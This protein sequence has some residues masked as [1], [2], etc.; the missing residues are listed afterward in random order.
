MAASSRLNQEAPLVPTDSRLPEVDAVT[1]EEEQLLNS[2]I[3]RVNQT[4]LQEKDVDAEALL[5][6]GLGGNPNVLYILAQC[7]LVQNIALDQ[8]KAQVA[9]LQQQVQQAQQQPAHAT[10]F[11]GN[12]LGHHDP[13]PLP[14]TFA[15]PQQSYVPPPGY[16][17]PQY[18]QPLYIPGSQPSFM[19]GAMQTAAGV[20]AGALAFEGVEAVLHGLGGFGHTGYGWGGPGMGMGGF[21]MGSGMMGGGFERPEETIVNNYYDQPGGQEQHFHESADRTGADQGGARLSDASYEQSGDNQGS[22][23]NAGLDDNGG[24]DNIAQDDGSGFDDGGSFDDGGGGG[25]FS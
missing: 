15:P 14:Q 19:R 6:R 24:D 11:L 16:F 9:Q 21:G 3:E 23:D 20:A 18:A 1:A 13:A 7:V 22:F 8:A 12:L 4:K 10:S 5:S 25:D 2:L 17:D